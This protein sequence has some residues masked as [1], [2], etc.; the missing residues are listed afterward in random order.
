MH[1][2]M[3]GRNTGRCE[4]IAVE[5]SNVETSLLPPISTGQAFFQETFA[6]LP[7]HIRNELLLGRLAYHSPVSAKMPTSLATRCVLLSAWLFDT[8]TSCE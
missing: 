7:L 3:V 1:Y 6:G 2:L 5:E 4:F 8:L